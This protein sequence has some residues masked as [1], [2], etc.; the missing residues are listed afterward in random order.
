M[1]QW[2]IIFFIGLIWFDF[3][4]WKEWIMFLVKSY[5]ISWI[6]LGGLSFL[7]VYCNSL[8]LVSNCFKSIMDFLEFTSLTF[9]L[10][11][12]QWLVCRTCKGPIFTTF[13]NLHSKSWDYNG[14]YE[15]RGCF[16]LLAIPPL[17]THLPT[18]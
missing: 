2:A 18:L 12:T 16:K 13:G 1:K 8:L 9:L 10:F 5:K 6:N 15:E 7:W 3:S 17:P 14:Y 4:S 11:S